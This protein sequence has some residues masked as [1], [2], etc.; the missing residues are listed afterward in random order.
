MHF[1]T[2][3]YRKYWHK[4]C[5][6]VNQRWFHNLHLPSREQTAPEH[7]MGDFPEN[8]W[9]MIAT[10]LPDDL[11]GAN[12]LDIDCNGDYYS[13]EL[14]R[15]GAQVTAIHIDEHYLRQGR[16]AAEILNLHSCIEFRRASVYGTTRY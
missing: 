10:A 8:R 16:W 13:F 4:N 14:A 12:A 7:F 6:L 11:A 9:R 3:T 15:R 1:A 5:R 2:A